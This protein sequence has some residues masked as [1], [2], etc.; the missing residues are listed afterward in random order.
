MNGQPLILAANPAP[1]GISYS[2]PRT[3]MWLLLMLFVAS[4]VFD[5]ADRLLGL[6]VYLF[7]G[8]WFFGALVALS[9]RRRTQLDPQLLAYVLLFIA[10]PVFSIMWYSAVRGGDPFE[11]WQ[12]L[13]G[14]LLISL[15][16]LLQVQRIDLMPGMCAMLTVLSVVIICT[17][18]VVVTFPPAFAA[19]YLFGSA[20]GVVSMGEREYGGG[21][22][23]LMVYFVT[24]P[25]L[26]MAIAFYFHRARFATEARTK[27][28]FYFV[29]AVNVAG[30]ILAGTRNN[31]AVAVMSPIVLHFMFARDKIL[32]GILAL[33]FATLIVVV[34]V[35]QIFNLL[36]PT[37]FSNQ[38]KL[39]LLS[40]YGTI[41]DDPMTLLFGHGLGAYQFWDA[42]GDYFYISELTYLELVR[43][44]GVFGAAA[45]LA[46]LFYPIV[47]A[48]LLDRNFPY[49]HIIVAYAFYL[50]MCASNPNM[51][52][53][54][55]ILILAIILATISRT[56][57]QEAIK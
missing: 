25:M 55:G 20:T 24:S 57:A 8:C 29:T 1:K 48:F 31:L 42:R 52:S 23:L 4:C 47:H 19:L 22:R 26:V 51:F 27:A 15:A 3:L 28:W 12:L 49:K 40:Q 32:H 53:S 14:Y 11:G 50:L 10:I 7:L 43:N 13:K 37:E 46:L 45:M 17:F 9:E 18:I 5:P 34:F 16:I 36:D 2:I 33:G 30:M 21:L 56:K 38:L 41:L 6:K 35:E 44:F 54:M 39:A